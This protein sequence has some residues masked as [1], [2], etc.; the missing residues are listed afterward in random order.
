MATK[1]QNKEGKQNIWQK[2]HYVMKNAGYI[3]RKKSSM[4]YKTVTHNDVTDSVRK[5]ITE[6]GLIIIPEVTS[7]SR[8]GNIHSVVMSIH[9]MDIDSGETVEIKGFPGT[10][11]DPQDKGY[12]K[13]ISYAFKY[14]L[15]KLFLLEIGDD[16]EV[17]RHQIK[18]IEPTKEVDPKVKKE[19]EESAKQGY[20]SLKDKWNELKGEKLDGFTQ[21]EKDEL[22]KTAIKAD[23]KEAERNVE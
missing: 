8:E 16:E 14:I 11:I 10:G 6:V 22:K 15:Q 3:Q 21:D 9:I 23:E 2:I 20:A 7:N 4:P 5:Q 19:L 12:G 18:A 1:K 17:D 13:A